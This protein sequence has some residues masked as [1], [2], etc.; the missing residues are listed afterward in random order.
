MKIAFHSGLAVALL[1]LTSGIARADLLN[2]TINADITLQGQDDNGFYTIDVFN[3]SINVGGGFNNSYNFFRQ[4]TEDG[5]ATASNQLTGN[6]G[7]S[8]TGDTITITFNGQAQPVELTG[9]F[10]GLPGTIT[11][12][13][14]V[15][16]GFM[17][18]VSL[19]LPNAFT[20]TSVTTEAFYLG[21][22]PGTSTSQVETLTFGSAP[23]PPVPE[24]SSVVLV[25]TGLLSAFEVVRRR[26]RSSARSF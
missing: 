23:P 12:V 21:Y 3:G 13:S 16:S 20:G 10:T 6:V 25:G 14:E 4:N 26:V 1:T 8:I 22:Q 18:G 17:D 2:S 9:A 19:P 24:P 7:L 15:D 11:A 5:F